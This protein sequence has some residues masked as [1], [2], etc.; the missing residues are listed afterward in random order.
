MYISDKNRLAMVGSPVSPDTYYKLPFGPVPYLANEYLSKYAFVSG[1]PAPYLGV[2]MNQI[3]KQEGDHFVSGCIEPDMGYI[4]KIDC[5]ALDAAIAEIRA[6]GIGPSGFAARTQLTHDT[7]WNGTNGGGQIS[8]RDMLLASG[9]S[10]EV[11]AAF[12][13]HQELD[14]LLGA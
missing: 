2:P 8:L 5:L 14:T 11:V 4:S 9:A 3:F 7:A 1:N 12:D 10:P 6:I 13:D